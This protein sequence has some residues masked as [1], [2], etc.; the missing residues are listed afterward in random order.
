LTISTVGLGTGKGRVLRE[1]FW[2][3]FF[4]VLKVG[5]RIWKENRV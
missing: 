2:G 3:G 4:G 5:E 1:A